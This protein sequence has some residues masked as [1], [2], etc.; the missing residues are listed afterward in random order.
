MSKKS[1]G[2]KVLMVTVRKFNVC[3]VLKNRGV[4]QSTAKVRIRGSD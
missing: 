1:E 3:V 2:E 4:L